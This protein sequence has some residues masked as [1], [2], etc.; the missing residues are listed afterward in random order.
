MT[1]FELIEKIQGVTGETKREAAAIV[2][3]V[4]TIMKETLIQGENLK[5]SGFGN[6]E[7]REKAPRTGRNPQTGEAI[8][9]NRRRVLSFKPGTVLKAQINPAKS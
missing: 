6:F 9:I 4:F 1:K 3:T 2:E 7:V 5:I 8:T